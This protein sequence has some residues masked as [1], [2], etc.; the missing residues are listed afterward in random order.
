[1]GSYAKGRW[2]SVS[3]RPGESEPAGMARSAALL[4]W[5]QAFGLTAA[6]PVQL[7][8]DPPWSPVFTG[9]TVTLTCR[10]PP[11][12]PR[13]PTAWF[14]DGSFW[15]QTESDRL[16]VSRNQPGSQSYQCRRDGSALSRPVTL[17]FAYAWLVLQ[18]PA[19]PLLEGDA[20]LLRCRGWRDGRLRHVRFW[21]DGADVSPRPAGAELLLPSVQRGDGGRYRCTATIQHLLERNEESEEV[22]VS[23]QELF[24]TPALS[25]GGSAEPLEGSTLALSC[26]THLNPLRP[27][28]VLQHLFYR[29]GA[30][31][32]GPEGSPEYRL[33]AVG[34]ADSGVYSCEVQTDTASVR[35]HSAPIAIV[36][37]R[38]PVSGVALEVQPRGGQLV[39]GECLVL[40]CSVAAGT[41]PISFSW[42]REGSAQALARSPRYEIAAAQ[43]GD[44]GRYHCSASNGLAPARSPGVQVTVVVPV[45]GATI[46]VEGTE[47]ALTAGESLNLS[48]S[49][50]AGTAPVAF[51]WLHNG[52][53]LPAASGPLLALEAVRP[54][55]AGT[56]QC[57]ASNQLNPQRV[58]RVRSQ[59]LALSVTARPDAAVAAGVSVSLLVLLAAT[60]ALGWHLR[61]RRR[62]E[63]AGARGRGRRPLSPS[64]P[65][66]PAAHPG[67]SA[68]PSPAGEDSA[69][70]YSNVRPGALAA[71][72][73][74]YSTITI[75]QRDT[76]GPAG[77]SLAQQ[78]SPITYMVLP[79]AR[80]GAAATQHGRLPSDSYE[81]VPLP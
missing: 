40:S 28:T 21:R 3:S 71:E 10:P 34:L 24:S 79:G 27:N 65:R 32:A 19:L 25:L 56:Y 69:V 11:A 67:P 64:L 63:A 80:R 73:V 4:L 13:G 37:R 54:A 30:I 2:P 58:F 52:H 76:D 8:L 81:N 15:R 42:H 46:A 35:K 57:V 14:L 49:V 72:D 36:V 62:A 9:E 31:L 74:L 59:L 18:A 66:D 75:K 51:A 7:A 61:R 16:A 60:A 68:P 22:S 50:Q 44:S 17:G 12:A 78:E 1:M 29:D 20:L 48:C 77:P 41:G 53:Q 70:L 55:H 23:V 45:A 39:Q 47:P 33:P 43:P 6:Q 26:V 5:A 38:V